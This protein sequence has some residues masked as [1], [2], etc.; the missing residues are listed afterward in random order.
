MRD[1]HLLDSGKLLVFLFCEIMREVAHISLSTRLLASIAYQSCYLSI[2]DN[3]ATRSSMHASIA[4]FRECF[5][6][7]EE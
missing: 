3:V 7:F 1:L 6:H 2:V 5:E 4:S